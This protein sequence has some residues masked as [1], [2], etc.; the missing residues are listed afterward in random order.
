MPS[1]EESLILCELTLKTQSMT[2]NAVERLSKYR[3]DRVRPEKEAQ[4]GG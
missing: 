1:E 4:S 2:P 3:D